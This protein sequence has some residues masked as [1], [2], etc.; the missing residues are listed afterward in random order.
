MR[1]SYK[2]NYT[3][4]KGIHLINLPEYILILKNG[5]LNVDDDTEPEKYF[6]HLV[7]NGDYHLYSSCAIE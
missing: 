3:C 1:M 5:L 6:D 4:K 2:E 7:Q